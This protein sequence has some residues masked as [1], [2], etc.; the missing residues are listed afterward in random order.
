MA[1]YSGTSFDWSWKSYTCTVFHLRPHDDRITMTSTKDSGLHF[2][3]YC[4]LSGSCLDCLTLVTFFKKVHTAISNQSGNY[5]SETG[6]ASL[7]SFLSSVRRENPNSGTG[8]SIGKFDFP[9]H[10]LLDQQLSKW[11]YWMPQCSSL[12]WTDEKL[13]WGYCTEGRNSG[14]EGPKKRRSIL[15]KTLS[16]EGAVSI[17]VSCSRSSKQGFRGST[18]QNSHL[19]T[20]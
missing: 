10:G 6:H 12:F 15:G 5:S 7:G 11:I 13:S 8:R 18:G 16:V 2:L 19:Y 9:N 17:K 4:I 1:A 3:E 14:W 20:S